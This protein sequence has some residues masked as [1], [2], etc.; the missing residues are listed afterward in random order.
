MRAARSCTLSTRSWP[1]LLFLTGLPT[2]I[3]LQLRPAEVT[4]HRSPSARYG[5]NV[6]KLFKRWIWRCI[7]GHRF[8]LPGPGSPCLSSSLPSSSSHCYTPMRGLGLRPEQVKSRSETE[9]TKLAF[10]RILMARNPHPLLLPQC[11]P[12]ALPSLSLLLLLLSTP[13]VL[14]IQGHAGATPQASVCRYLTA[15]KIEF[16]LLLTAL[17]LHKGGARALPQAGRSTTLEHCA[18]SR[19]STILRNTKKKRYW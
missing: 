14:A 16:L 2:S 9:G 4:I 5:A 11:R 17:P 15:W 8:R 6:G 1:L 19:L 3:H 12:S 13:R 7:M 18:R 10:R